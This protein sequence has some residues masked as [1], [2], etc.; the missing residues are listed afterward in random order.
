MKISLFLGLSA[1][2][3]FASAAQ[4]VSAGSTSVLKTFQIYHALK[5]GAFTPRGT[6]ELSAGEGGAIV[7]TFIM[8]ESKP[9]N[10]GILEGLDAIVSNNGFYRIKLEDKESGSA[11]VASVPACDVRRANFREQIGLTLGNTGSIISLSYKPLVSPLAPQCH[12][13]KSFMDSKEDKEYK[14]TTTVN[15]STATPGMTIPTVLPN[16]N[17]P[18]GYNWIKR[19]RKI[20]ESSTENINADESPNPDTGFDPEGEAKPEQHSFLRR[21]WYI[22]LPVTIMTFIGPEAAQDDQ[23]GA[24][25]GAEGA[26][27]VAG[28]TAAAGAAKASTGRQRRGKRS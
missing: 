21:Y 4:E 10:D 8:D 28:A 9:L 5:P 13:L 16:S 22:I 27:R 17:A 2:I 1:L 3:K 18:M 12:E 11:V 6:I 20:A 15:Y 25:A 26:G 7:S 24:A 19:G 14:F 23:Q